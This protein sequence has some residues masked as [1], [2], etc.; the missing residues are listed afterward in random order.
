MR[1]LSVYEREFL[2]KDDAYR[3]GWYFLFMKVEHGPYDTMEEASAALEELLDSRQ[4]CK[5]CGD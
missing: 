4:N 5:N 1:S 3:N 2:N